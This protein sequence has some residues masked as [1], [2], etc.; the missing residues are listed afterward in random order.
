MEEIFEK[1]RENENTEFQKKEKRWF[2]GHAYFPLF[3]YHLNYKYLTGEIKT[4][5]EFRQ[6]E[7][8][9]PSMIDGGAFGDRH[10]CEVNC[11][12]SVNKE[13]PMFRISQRSILARLLKKAPALLYNIKCNETELKK[14]LER[15]QNLNEIFQIVE[16]SP[17]FSPFIEGKMNN[18]NYELNIGYNTQQKNGNTLFL[19]NE[20]CKNV[21]EYINE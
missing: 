12:I 20:F 15:N 10:I 19:I 1:L 17:E 2:N 18:G 4:H 13:F 11:V 5:Y 21:I 9:K 14:M 8:S 16:N 3:N 6:S 7:F